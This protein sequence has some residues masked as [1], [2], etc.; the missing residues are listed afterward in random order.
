ME[1]I[2]YLAQDNSNNN[3]LGDT[4]QTTE[5][6]YKNRFKMII[7][8]DFNFNFFHLLEIRII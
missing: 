5:A 1:Q 6:S 3:Y 8:F 4:G 7:W 2:N